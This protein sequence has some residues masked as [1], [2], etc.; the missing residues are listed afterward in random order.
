MAH[1]VLQCPVTTCDKGDGSPYKTEKLAPDMAMEM[2]RMHNTA[3]HPQTGPTVREGRPQAERV[4]RPILTLTGQSITQD[5]YEH[6]LYLFSQYK[7]RLG[8]GH[9]SAILL[10]E[11]LA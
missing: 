5:E 11:C 4:K 6:F 2:M 1:I 10:R 9:D 7:T 3:I 8:P